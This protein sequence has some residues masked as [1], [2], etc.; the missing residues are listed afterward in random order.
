[1]PKPIMKLMQVEGLTRENVA[2]HLQ[3]YRL[4]L[5]RM[6]APGMTAL[7]PA[8]KAKIPD[9]TLK[10]CLLSGDMRTA[11]RGALSTMEALW[12]PSMDSCRGVRALAARLKG[13]FLPE[14]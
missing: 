9:A 10:I 14:L 4:Y 7:P 5:K 13:P 1:M 2:S 8:R 3:K 12:P 11:V 6:T